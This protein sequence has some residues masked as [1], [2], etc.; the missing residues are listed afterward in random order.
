M[1]KKAA[2][3]SGQP[4]AIRLGDAANVFTGIGVSRE[5]TIEREGEKLPMIGVRDIADDAVAPIA[6]LDTVGFA[7]PEKADAY[8]VRDGD[9]L[10]TGRGTALKFG[11]VGRETEGAIASGN[12][13]VIRTL[14]EVEPAA[15]YAVLSSEAYRPKIE[16]LRRG[17]TTLLSLSAKDLAKLELQ[18]P[19]IA[20]QR[21][22]AALV[23]EAREA[24][25]TAINAAEIRRNLARQL[26]MQRLFGSMN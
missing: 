16:L 3:N 11:L 8:R 13:I 18:L 7:R 2:R 26:I 4:S 15:L 12:V 14:G 17:S 19:P 10:V 9:I 6:A 5:D 22:I 20:E 25:H 24:Y 21:L 1:I 23:V